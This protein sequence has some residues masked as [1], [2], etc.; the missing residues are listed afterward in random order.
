MP[1]LPLAAIPVPFNDDAV[2]ITDLHWSDGDQPTRIAVT[3]RRSGRSCIVEFDVVIGLRMLDELDL[4]STWQQAPADILKSS[5]LFAVR[6]GGWFE[7]EATRPDFYTQ[8]V[9]Q[10]PS[11]FLVVGFQDCL[12]VLAL[13]I[14]RIQ[15]ISSGA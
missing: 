8:H 15:E 3:S 9:L 11:E 13:S 6:S 14:P 2:K 12:S 10:K 5:W 4:A 1:D 7:L